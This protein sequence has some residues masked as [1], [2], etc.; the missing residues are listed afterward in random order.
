[1]CKLRTLSSNKN[2]TNID[3][4]VYKREKYI[5][6][7]KNIIQF[8]ANLDDLLRPEWMNEYISEIKN[9]D[10][11]INTIVEKINQLFY[12]SGKCCLK[13]FR[14]QSSYQHQKWFDKTCKILKSDKYHL[15]HKFRQYRTDKNL[16]LYLQAKT[17]FKNYCDKVKQEY[18]NRELDKLID[19]SNDPKA[20]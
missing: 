18:Y 13:T 11:S 12:D 7:E 2:E 17:T 16:R 20:F 19:K 4:N 6:N 8:K 14:K 9:F 10:I 5:F 1:M 15:L 3:A